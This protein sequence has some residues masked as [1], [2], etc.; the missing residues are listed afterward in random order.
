MNGQ[1]FL[2]IQYEKRPVR[3]THIL[4]GELRPTAAVRGHRQRTVPLLQH[5]WSQTGSENVNKN[6]D[7]AD[8]GSYRKMVAQK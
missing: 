8:N 1:A 2:D 7:D 5:T 3:S 4:A 6:R